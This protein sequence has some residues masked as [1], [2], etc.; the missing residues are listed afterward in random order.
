VQSGRKDSRRVFKLIKGFPDEIR[1]TWASR[2]WWC[3]EESRIKATIRE[4][5][6]KTRRPRQCESVGLDV[7]KQLEQREFPLATQLFNKL[8]AAN[9]PLYGIFEGTRIY[10][11]PDEHRVKNGIVTIVENKSTASKPD[12]YQTCQSIFQVRTYAF[13]EQQIIP[14]FGYKL[15]NLHRVM[16]WRRPTKRKKKLTLLEVVWVPTHESDMLKFQQDLRLIFQVWRGLRPPPAPAIFKCRQCSLFYKVRCRFYRRELELPT[17]KEWF[18]RFV[19]KSRRTK[20]DVERF[21]H[22]K[23]FES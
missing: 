3:A 13:I 5:R 2:F 10:I 22:E 14:R 20:Q 15:G 17:K 11:H 1:A 6:D 7:H 21:E 23:P 12:I 4:P 8:L 19:K 16:Y 9:L 18:K